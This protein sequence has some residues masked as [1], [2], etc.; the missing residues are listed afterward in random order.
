MGWKFAEVEFLAFFAVMLRQYR[1]K[2]GEGVSKD[3]TEKQIF[4]RCAG[5]ITLSPYDNVKLVLD[6]RR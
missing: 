3:L 5:D 4:L 1:V 2:L 6:K